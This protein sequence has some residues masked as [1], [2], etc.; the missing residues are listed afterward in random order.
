[1]RV[2]D[3]QGGFCKATHTLLPVGVGIH[4][5]NLPQNLQIKTTRNELAISKLT[6]E[7]S[8]KIILQDDVNTMPIHQD[9]RKTCLE[10][11]KAFQGIGIVFVVDGF[12]GMVP[13]DSIK[14]D[15]YLVLV[16]EKLRRLITLHL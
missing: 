15:G 16:P 4:Q 6:I 11:R 3:N 2:I 13:L 7:A 1:M 14:R 8:Q 9:T 10:I 12:L 5:I